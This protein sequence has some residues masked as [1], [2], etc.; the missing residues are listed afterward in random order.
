M[1]ERVFSAKDQ[2][3]YSW[4][5][6]QISSAPISAD[7]YRIFDLRLALPPAKTPEESIDLASRP[8][9]QGQALTAC[10]VPIS[11]HRSK[12]T[13]TPCEPVQL[14]SFD[15][16]RF[17]LHLEPGHRFRWHVTE[18]STGASVT[19]HCPSREAALAKLQDRVG[20]YRP[21]YFQERL[22][23]YRHEAYSRAKRSG[24]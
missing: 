23:S 19:N 11:R 14:K 24:R 7:G 15:Q 6:S 10:F 9:L 2:K 8:F 22:D 5:L 20:R 17:G 13:V 1:P 16:F 12:M 3:R 21:E 4:L 18:F